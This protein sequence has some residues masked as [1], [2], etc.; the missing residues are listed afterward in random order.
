MFRIFVET[1]GFAS[2]RDI[3]RHILPPPPPPPPSCLAVLPINT[4][5]NAPP[6][7]S[8]DP[9]ANLLQPPETVA[10]CGDCQ[11]DDRVGTDGRCSVTHDETPNVDPFSELQAIE[12]Q[13]N[14]WQINFP[15]VEPGASVLSNTFQTQSLS[16]C[17]S[18][19][20][21]FKVESPS[22]EGQL[23]FDDYGSSNASVPTPDLFHPI[24]RH[25]PYTEIMPETISTFEQTETPQGNHLYESS[26][27][28]VQEPDWTNDALTLQTLLH[29]VQSPGTTT[30]PVTV[31]GNHTP[32]TIDGIVSPWPALKI[33]G[34]WGV[35]QQPSVIQNDHDVLWNEPQ[36]YSDIDPQQD[37]F[38]QFTETSDD[39][40]GL[41]YIVGPGFETFG[42]Q[43]SSSS[44][45]FDTTCVP[46]SFPNFYQQ[47]DATQLQDFNK[48]PY[49]N[50]NNYIPFSNGL[51][52]TNSAGSFFNTFGQISSY[53]PSYTERMNSWTND[54]RNALLIECKRRGLSYRDIKKIGGF[55]EAESTLRGRYRTLTKSKDQRVRRPHWKDNDVSI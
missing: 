7:M 5:G 48:I 31:A 51:P 55:R 24:P 11:M 14:H 1:D 50:P 23:M 32:S 8:F 29:E 18:H 20:A 45:P 46:T 4:S 39:I 27:R 28:L 6:Q 13:Y 43:S 21:T 2:D 35:Q 53:Q 36:V 41:P 3:E 15:V 25:I 12:E 9:Q 54:A 33:Q 16:E 17:S 49:P 30:S 37:Q 19:W 34:H 22:P 26:G 44:S 10:K 38:C 42:A 52:Q 47:G 40:N